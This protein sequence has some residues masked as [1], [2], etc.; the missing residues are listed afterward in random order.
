[1]HYFCNLCIGY[2]FNSLKLS[3]GGPKNLLSLQDMM[4]KLDNNSL[5]N[6]AAKAG[7]YLGA[8]CITC[9]T[10]REL[11]HASGIEF[12]KTA[13]DVILW[14]VQFLSCILLVKDVMISVRDRYEGVKMADT[15]RLGRRAALLSGLLLASAQTLFIL[16][17][18]EADMN[19]YIDALTAA[20]PVGS[21]GREQVEEAMDNL[22]VLTFFSQWI[23]CYLYGTGLSAVM[24]RY[25]FL[26]KLFG[27]VPP[28]DENKPDEQ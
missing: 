3:P 13:A 14:T 23:Y 28:K 6:E 2:A 9:L 19:A 11:A 17:M 8:V 24:S 10:L 16:R 7:A 18:S 26:Q 22:P 4:K 25:I 20:L 27:M 21:A 5:W 1:M 12:L 15:F